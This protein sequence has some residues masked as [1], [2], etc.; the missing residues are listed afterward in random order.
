MK[1][2]SLLIIILILLCVACGVKIQTNTSSTSMV[3]MKNGGYYTISQNKNGPVYV[4]SAVPISEGF[5]LEDTLHQR[6]FVLSSFD[7]VSGKKYW[8]EF[9]YYKLIQRSLQY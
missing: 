3:P 1:K 5:S 6:M 2:I 9:Y 7:V 8:N 4:Y